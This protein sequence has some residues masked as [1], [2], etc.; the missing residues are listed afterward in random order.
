MWAALFLDRG[1][2]ASPSLDP[3][4][5]SKLSSSGRPLLVSYIM[6]SSCSPVVGRDLLMRS[7]FLQAVFDVR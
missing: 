7:Y 2:G 1:A 5:V 4:S 3:S 6:V